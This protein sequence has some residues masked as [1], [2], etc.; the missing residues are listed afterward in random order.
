MQMRDKWSIAKR[1]LIIAQLN[2]TI[3]VT[4]RYKQL[5]VFVY[6]KVIG[7]KV[8]VIKKSKESVV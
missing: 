5:D 7:L 1:K 3:F 4:L 6:M 8:F 2:K